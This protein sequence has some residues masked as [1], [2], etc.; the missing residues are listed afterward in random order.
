MTDETQEIAPADG[1]PVEVE[2][3]AT[4]EQVADKQ[5]A[6]DTGAERI[7]QPRD[8]KG[9]F[10]S[11]QAR[12]DKV[13]WEKHEAQ[14]QA[15][16]YRQQL[17]DM[18]KQQ[19]PPP[20]AE[21]KPVPTLE[22]VGFDEIKYQQALATHYRA[23]A[24]AVA[25]AAVADELRA[26]REQ[27]QAAKRQETFQTRQVEFAKTVEDYDRV[28]YNPAIAINANMAEDIAASDL[29]PQ[30][31]YYLGKNPELAYQI[32]RLPARAAAREL[33]KIEAKLSAPKAAPALTKAP[34]P[35]PK[36]AA[37]DPEIERDPEK[38]TPSEWRVMRDKEILRQRK[39]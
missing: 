14:R 22:S 16:H 26:E 28:V 39:G 38:M 15:D 1:A 27:Q 19:A 10:E 35:P 24:I 13:T 21:A 32:A 4:P 30:L 17:E 18:Q 3:P 29:G 31:A 12:I 37:S 6:D 25:K 20:V 36:L 33:G 5:P 9:R 23:E 7:E 2:S 11:V 8:E 34:P